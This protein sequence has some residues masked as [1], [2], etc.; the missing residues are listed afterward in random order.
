MDDINNPNYCPLFFKGMYAWIDGQQSHVG[1][2]CMSG[3]SKNI[4]APDFHHLYLEHTRNSWSAGPRAGCKQCWHTEQRGHTSNRQY[5]ITW[6]KNQNLDPTTTEL[7]RLDFS[8]GSLC[9][10]KCIMC[11]AGS[12][13]TWAAEDAKFGINKYRHNV[14]SVTDQLDQITS[15]DVSKL[16]QVY[17]TGGEPMMSNRMIMLLKH[18]KNTGNISQLEFSC[19]T[20][21]SVLPGAELIELWNQCKS[22]DIHFSIDGVGREFEYIRNPLKWSEVE[23]NIMFVKSLGFNVNIAMA[24]GV[25]NIDIMQDIH[26]WFI[27]LHLPE[28]AFVVNPCWGELSLDSASEEL[29]QL[30]RQQLSTQTHSWTAA[31]AS[32]I[33]SPGKSNDS[34]WQQW[35]AKIDLRRN[36]DW[37]HELPKLA[38]PQS[39]YE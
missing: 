19:N 36:C 13:T 4:P 21:G 10:A 20:N 3:A 26:S 17:F 22:V 5:H 28:S 33:Q 6:L 15:I 25:H 27:S 30:W 16:K 1:H 29:K 37:Q 11:N 9:N 23:S 35:L 8:V 14:K 39:P 38:T 7:L 32:M 31:V 2:C 12:S 18:I 34:V 24:V